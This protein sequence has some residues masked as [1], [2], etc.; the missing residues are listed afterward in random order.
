MNYNLNQWAA[1]GK[2]DP[3]NGGKLIAKIASLV[4]IA[5]NLGEKQIAESMPRAWGPA[6]GPSEAVAQAGP[7]CGAGPRAGRPLRR[8]VRIRLSS[9]PPAPAGP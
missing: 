2:I 8:W 7:A 5:D 6:G 4:L 1:A 3:Y 9:H